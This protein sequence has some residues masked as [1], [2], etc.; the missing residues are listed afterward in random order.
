MVVW[1][2]AGRKRL[3]KQVGD[4]AFPLGIETGALVKFGILD[5]STK[6]APEKAGGRSGYGCREGGSGETLVNGR[7]CGRKQ[8]G[9][10]FL[11]Y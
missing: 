5:T 3:R 11:F 7:A 6:D 2:R 8:V 4:S 10:L 1:T 9:D